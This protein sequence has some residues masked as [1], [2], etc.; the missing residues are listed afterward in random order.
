MKTVSHNPEFWKVFSMGSVRTEFSLNLSQQDC[1]YLNIN[2]EKLNSVHEI[3][4]LLKRDDVKT[5]IKY[6][7]KNGLNYLIYFLNKTNPNKTFIE[8][9]AL[10]TLTNELPSLKDLIKC[11]MEF[12]FIFLL[13]ANIVN[14]T[15]LSF[16][17]NID[18]LEPQV[19]DI[20]I[21]KSNVQRDD[22]SKENK[23]GNIKVE[24]NSYDYIILDLNEILYLK[25]Q[26]LTL[27]DL[28]EFLYTK[29][30]SGSNF[31][32]ILIFPN[33]IYF[34]IEDLKELLE[35]YA[36]SDVIIFETSELI[37]IGRVMG[38]EEIDEKNVEKV[39]LLEEMKTVIVSPTKT[40]KNI[41]ILDEFHQFT[42]IT[43]EN[44]TNKIVYQQSFFF[45]IGLKFDYFKTI[46]NNFD[47]LKNVFY[48]T[49]LSRTIHKES[50]ESSFSIAKDTFKKVLELIQ[51]QNEIPEDKDY[52]LIGSKEK[53]KLNNVL[54][55][56][57]NVKNIKQIVDQNTKRENNFRLDGILI[58]T[59][60]K[61][62]EYNPLFDNN[63]S[64]FLASP[65]VRKHL[66]K[67]GFMDEAGNM[68]NSKA[69]NYI[70]KYRNSN[71]NLKN[72]SEQEEKRN[73]NLFDL[74]SAQDST[75]FNINNITANKLPGS[76][77]TTGDKNRS[78]SLEQ[79]QG[80]NKNFNK[81]V[82]NNEFISTTTN[83]PNINSLSKGKVSS[84]EN[85]FYPAGK[86]KFNSNK[87]KTAYNDKSGYYSQNVY[88]KGSSLGVSNTQRSNSKYIYLQGNNA[89]N[90][91]PLKN[92]SKHTKKGNKN[93]R[94]G[95]E[96]GR[97][98]PIVINQIEETKVKNEK[99]SMKNLQKG[100][101]KKVIKKAEFF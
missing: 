101:S 90:E 28:I 82:K 32:I 6:T 67:M 41:M 51:T 25:Q 33:A 20:P 37:K 7:P 13:E 42:V 53:P 10:N 97:I 99:D 39:L 98:M 12:N 5:K 22:L 35:L 69:L 80:K 72:F 30:S 9:L 18:G 31:H 47:L 66:V 48:G 45:D 73:K 50:Y 49:F 70:N 86:S 83:L 57:S 81:L 91:E 95:E 55:K 15:N 24:F 92:N 64:S 62:V 4:S 78:F 14:K 88:L 27:T 36:L 74:A 58:S 77:Y 23:F 94:N 8:H 59:N 68:V 19:V 93:E 84:T 56:K 79:E 46:S 16:S 75:G 3:Y 44:E 1:Q 38:H 17:F 100:N 60:K 63:C 85:Q 2:K 26:D 29:L 11:E 52:F 65:I 96:E 61:V 89:E 76:L 34:N 43:K 87:V 21:N 54:D 40:K 71:L